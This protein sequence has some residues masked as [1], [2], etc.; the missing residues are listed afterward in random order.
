MCERAM[1]IQVLWR[2][3]MADWYYNKIGHIDW[4]RVDRHPTGKH[5]DDLDID[6]NEEINFIWLPRQDQLQEIVGSSSYNTFY[7]LV[8]EMTM[9]EF[10]DS[11]KPVKDEDSIEMI[12]LHYV[13]L[14]KYNKTW[15]DEN[16]V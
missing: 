2:P 5:L 14:K 7:E 12:W 1:E 9:Y 4:V 13:M 15:H 11:W 8:Q 16:W 10:L 3:H 6:Y